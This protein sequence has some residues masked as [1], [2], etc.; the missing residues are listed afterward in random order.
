MCH[1]A[2]LFFYYY[3]KFSVK[4]LLDIFIN[5]LDVS[6][7]G[8]SKGPVLG[9]CP[10]T[11]QERAAAAKKYNMTLSEYEAY[12]NKGEGSVLISII[13]T[14]CSFLK[15]VLNYQSSNLALFA[16]YEISVGF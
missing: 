5:G 12:P 13:L 2:W 1:F 11:L 6:A 16:R 9:P 3:R 10:A 4:I 8:E 14:C 7:S 15:S